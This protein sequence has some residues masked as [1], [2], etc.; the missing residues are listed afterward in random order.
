M[1]SKGEKELKQT[2]VG[3]VLGVLL[4]FLLPSIVLA[5]EH[6]TLLPYKVEDQ[7]LKGKAE[8]KT[9]VHVHVDD[10]LYTSQADESGSF[11]IKLPQPVGMKSVHLYILDIDGYKENQI[12]YEPTNPTST[13]E[14]LPS[15]TYVGQTENS[16]YLMTSPDA[17][18][19]ASYEGDIYTGRQ[20]LLVPKGVMS[21][22]RVYAK[23]D[24]GAK[25]ETTLLSTK[26]PATIVIEPYA[27]ETKRFVG[28]A[29]PYAVLTFKEEETGATWT[30]VADPKGNV[31]FPY[32]PTLETVKTGRTLQVVSAG[33]VST[34]TTAILPAYQPSLTATYYL[35]VEAPQNQIEGLTY[36]NSQ[37]LLDDTICATSDATGYFQCDVTEMQE[38]VHEVTFKHDE[39]SRSTFVELPAR[40]ESFPLTLDQPISSEHPV[41]S[42]KTIPKRDF[43]V[44]YDGLR[45]PLTS[46]ENG[47]FQMEFP[48]QYKGEIRLSV[49]SLDGT[50]YEVRSWTVQDRRPLAKPAMSFNGNTLELTNP[51][52][53][54]PDVTGKIIIE[55]TDGSF[56]AQ[57]FL[58]PKRDTE[59]QPIQITGIQEGDR[60]TLTLVTDEQD[61][62]KATFEGVLHPLT[63]MNLDSFGP[64]DQTLTGK[65]E[66]GTRIRLEMPIAYDTYNSGGYTIFEGTVS[67][68]G[69]FL[70]K[71][72]S[73]D[74]SKTRSIDYSGWMRISIT[75]PGTKDVLKYNRQLTDETVPAIRIPKISD[76]KR[77]V[78][79]KSDDL[80]KSADV[81]YYKG[82][83]LVKTVKLD[84][85]RFGFY[86]H[87]WDSQTSRTFKQDGITRIEVRGT[88]RSD[89][90]S[91][92]VSTSILS[93][94]YPPLTVYVMRFGET[95]LQAKT[96]PRKKV[97][98]VIGEQKY[99]VIAD[100]KGL[101]TMRL[102]R[103]LTQQDIVR[104]TIRNEAGTA[105]TTEKRPVDYPVQDIHWSEKKNKIWFVT[106]D[107]HLRPSCYTF[108]INGKEVKLAGTRPRSVFALPKKMKAPFQVELTLR[109]SDGTARATLKKTIRSTYQNQKVTKL[110]ASAKTRLIKGIA[111]P[112]HAVEAY[113]D[114][115]MN[116]AGVDLYQ[117]QQFSMKA[118]RALRI[119]KTITIHSRDPF[120]QRSIVSLKIKD[121][122][123]PKT[124]T[125]SRITSKST[126]ITGKT[127]A[128]ANVVVTYKKKAY[129][130]QADAKGNY[131]LRI[132]AW[133]AGETVSIYAEDASKNR[134]ATV[135][136]KIVKS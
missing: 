66:P 126:R 32:T 9:T 5:T 117:D 87:T 15:V 73:I 105:K 44:E 2:I 26:V 13:A 55:H 53:G 7:I 132:N 107:T 93:T 81:R 64:Y 45:F 124:P 62:R 4:C 102:K 37:V 49:R 38:P 109:N 121:D 40:P 114:N 12:S 130:T 69:K 111:Q 128:K 91:D 125:V 78:L 6:P 83:T 76:S 131:L 71:T 80:L 3:Y 63:E 34:K 115:D 100:T 118:Y 82:E 120:G 112:Y 108:K 75:R 22:M 86:R 35:L 90:T 16:F 51:L 133:K 33:S 99:E 54:L 60:Y 74:T 103:A 21:E 50:F 106:Q 61:V 28:K 1:E 129:R 136:T 84:L 43:R 122:I 31:T 10:V 88:N 59:G 20:Q 123:A 94:T 89:M 19:Y 25:S 24:Q 39:R 29:W 30:V 113:D 67:K 36:A 18:I 56:D 110:T 135:I 47:Q 92:W 77:E 70:L 119:G 46:D 58:F 104:V 65:G 79:F 23:T 116:L 68:D 41:L 98:A 96:A 42:G 85:S 52:K 134:S 72:A 17:T 14:P 95:V 27:F 57:T 127:E 48:K 97:Q 101:V 8:A 11:S